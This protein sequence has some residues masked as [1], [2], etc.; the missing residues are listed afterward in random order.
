M[1]IFFDFDTRKTDHADDSD[2]SGISKP[3]ETRDT[4]YMR[5]KESKI[6]SIVKLKCFS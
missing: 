2:I 6:R 5:P 4:V 1:S 3:M